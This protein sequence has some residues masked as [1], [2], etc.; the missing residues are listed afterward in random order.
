MLSAYHVLRGTLLAGALA[1]AAAHVTEQTPPATSPRDLFR[2]LAGVTDGEWAAV[3]RGEAVSKVLDTSSREI[4]IAGAVRIA[5][6]SARLVAR[7]RDIDNLKRS[8]LVIEVG[9]FGANPQ[10]GDLQSAPFEEYNLDLRDCRPSDCRVR[11]AAPDIE[12]FHNEVDWRA[13]DWRARSAAVWRVVLSG[14][15]A[16]YARAGRRAL[17]VYANKREPLSVPSELSLLAREFGFVAALAPEFMAYL[18][19]FGPHPPDGIEQVLYWTKEDFGIRPVF[20]ISH[21]AIYRPPNNAG[22]TVI[23]TSQVYADHYLDAALT[24][25]LALDAPADDR[26]K[27]FYMIAVSRARTRSLSGLLRT[28]VRSTVQSRSREAMRKILSATKLNIER[29]GG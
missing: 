12:R 14:Y 22:A 26:T 2:T 21:Q 25:T 3:E 13:A 24:V 16:A 29:S 10:P 28:F 20:R 11:L 4:A 18:R 8:A 1:T 9:R 17:P 27:G 7:Y 6:S 19:D 23:A 5:S 15:A